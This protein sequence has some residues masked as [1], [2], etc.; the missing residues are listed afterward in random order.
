MSDGDVRIQKALADAGVASRRAAEALV[1]AG[2]VTVNGEPA[3]IGQ[4]VTVGSDRLAVDGRPVVVAGSGHL[5]QPALDVPRLEDE[6]AEDD[7][8][9]QLGRPRTGQPGQLDRPY[10]RGHGVR[11]GPVH[12]APAGRAGQHVRVDGGRRQTADQLLRPA[13]LVPAVA[14]ARGPRSAWTA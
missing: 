9:P 2:R 8:G 11:A 1:A 4:R 6:D 5:L 12:H 7:P 14:A 10:R 3:V 13:D